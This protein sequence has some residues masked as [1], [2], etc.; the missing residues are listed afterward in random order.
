MEEKTKNYN[1]EFGEIS[2]LYFDFEENENN[3]KKLLNNAFSFD[4]IQ[5]YLPENLGMNKLDFLFLY[6]F[7][8]SYNIKNVLELGCGSTSQFLD[9]L[10]IQ[11]T[12][13]ALEQLGGD[14]PLEFI[15]CDIYDIKID[16]MLA[17]KNSDMFL[18]DSLHTREMAEFYHE[19]LLKHFKLPVFIHDFTRQGTECYSEQKYWEDFLLNKTYKMLILSD[20]HPSDIQEGLRQSCA[21]ILP[22]D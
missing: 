9:N 6:K 1:D 8:K 21:I 4:E 2:E 7:I 22:V 16:L 5:E 11:R 14:I 19:N 15:K 18:I 13:F 20:L 10:N 12:T 3:I 17:A